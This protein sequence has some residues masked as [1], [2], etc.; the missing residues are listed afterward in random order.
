MATGD[1]AQ[2]LGLVL[3]AFN[4]SRGQLARSLG[5]DKSVVSRWASGVQAP[6][7]HNLSLLTAAVSRQRPGFTRGDWEF[8]INTFAGRLAALELGT[9][10]R[11]SIAVMPFE[12]RGADPA[13][14]YFVDGLA[15]EI[16]TALSCFKSLLVIARNSSFTYRGKPVDVRQVGR[17]LGVRYLLEGSVRR[18]G[19][20]VRITAQLVECTTGVHLWADRFDSTFTDVFDLQDHIAGQVVAAIAPMLDKAEIERVRRKPPGNLS[21]YDCY[22]RGLAQWRLT[23][24]EA[25]EESTQLFYRTIELDPEFATPYGLIA[26]ACI[27]RHHKGWSVDSRRE[28]AEIRRLAAVVSAIGAD[29]ALALCSAGYALGWVCNDFDGAGAMIDRGLLVNRNLAS[30]WEYRGWT[31]VFLGHHLSALGQFDLALRLSPRDPF[32]FTAERGKAMALLYLERFDEALHW[33][34]RALTHQPGEIGSLR[35]AAAVNALA[36]RLGEARRIMADILVAHPGMRLAGLVGDVVGIR[37]Q[38][39]LERLHLGLRLAGMPD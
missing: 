30:G 7:D 32:S 25:L 5:I 10:D 38:E 13:Q 36:G 28:E 16:I 8:D 4:L 12:N 27:E 17:E 21:A 6:T 35:V 1:F 29:D 33:A 11:P 23:T 9:P 34:S 37:R 20:R 39:D 2:K 24:Q 22:L 26:M 14:D 15:E 31:S 19:E 18:A 3:S